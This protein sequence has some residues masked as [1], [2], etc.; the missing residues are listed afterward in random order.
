[1]SAVAGAPVVVGVDG[2]PRSLE[3]VTTAAAEAALRERS[4]RIVHAFIWPT[5]K[6]GRLPG[7]PAPSLAPFEEQAKRYL[8]EAVHIAA[9]AAPDVPVTTELITGAAVPVLLAES[10]YADLIVLGDRGLGAFSGLIVGSVAVQIVT[11]GQCP[12]LVVRG[13]SRRAG[14]CV[15]GVDGSEASARAVEFAAKEAARRGAELVAVRAWQSLTSL[16]PGDVPPLSYDDSLVEEGERRLLTESLLGL[17]ERYPDLQIRQ[18]LTNGSAARVLTERSREA[19]LIV[20]GARGRGGFAG[21]ML[22][23]VSQHLIYKAQC[24]VAVIR[25]RKDG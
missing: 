1:M 20:V 25:G 10:R 14:P 13:E 16:S 17:G 18:E 2:S 6:M 24:P 4:L 3:A 23:S 22:G 9:E 21:L 15:V 5:M 7:M 11:Y 12:V 8:D 19:Q